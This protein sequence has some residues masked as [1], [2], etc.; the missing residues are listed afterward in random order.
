MTYPRIQVPLEFV[1]V[2][3]DL[4]TWKVPPQYLTGMSNALFRN[5]AIEAVRDKS[6]VLG[7]LTASLPLKLVYFSDLREW[8]Y[9][10]SEDQYSIDPGGPTET[11]ITLSG[12]L[13]TT[14]LSYFHSLFVHNGIV[15]HNNRSDAPMYYT[16]TAFVALPGYVS[17]WTNAPNF[18]RGIK[19]HLVA[20]GI[21]SQLNIVGWSDAADPGSAPGTWTPAADN[22]AGSVLLGRSTSI[23]L[24]AEQFREGLF[25]YLD[26]AVWNMQ[27]IGGNEVFGFSEVFSNLTALG[28]H[29][30]ARINNKHA[31]ITANDVVIHDGISIESLCRNKVRKEIFDNQIAYDDD[32][33][34]L[35]LAFYNRVNNE[36]WIC[37]P[38]KIGLGDSGLYFTA[39]FSLVT[40]EWSFRE[41]DFGASWLVNGGD[42]SD[43]NPAVGFESVLAIEAGGD[44][45]ELD[46]VTTAD[47]DGDMLLQRHDL[48]FGEPSRFKFI[49]GIRTLFD[50]TDELD[51][52]V[53]YRNDLSDAITW[54]SWAAV[55]D[56]L[57]YVDVVG[58]FISIEYRVDAS[59]DFWRISRTIFELEMRGY[60]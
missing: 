16:G 42:L 58:R 20:L 19:F 40:K 34:D 29:S 18:M 23:I 31:V 52:R 7:T 6:L 10:S 51:I 39:I 11:D 59:T 13:T 8:I 48:D 22:D 4:P 57:L 60:F 56:Q 44:I 12:G 36:L 26:G 9:V 41:M 21:G 3:T 27:F 25:I 35:S 37:V 54:N 5:G 46:A 1:G 50:G 28:A 32:V 15:V 14:T 47:N 2:N 38:S 53:G 43:S 49:R 30:V 17:E 45:Y 55:T 33:A 24:T